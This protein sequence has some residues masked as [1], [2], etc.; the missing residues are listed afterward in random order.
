MWYLCSIYFAIWEFRFIIPSHSSLL[1]VFLCIDSIDQTTLSVFASFSFRMWVELE[2]VSR[3]FVCHFRS[4]SGD[5]VHGKKGEVHNSQAH[6]CSL[7]HNFRFELNWIWFV[8]SFICLASVRF[9]I[10][11]RWN[12][13]TQSFLYCP[14]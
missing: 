13:V 11:F 8:L 4:T 6:F 7:P 9:F 12:F 1:C 2:Q 3:T 14:Q 10:I 5:E